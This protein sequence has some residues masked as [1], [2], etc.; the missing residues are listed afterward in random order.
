MRMK[1]RCKFEKYFRGRV[2]RIWQ[3]IYG[4]EEEEIK[5]SQNFLTLEAEGVLMLL[6]VMRE[7][8]G[9]GTDS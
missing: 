5:N 3:I 6:A 2:N 7:K 9:R 4:K 8:T 1:R